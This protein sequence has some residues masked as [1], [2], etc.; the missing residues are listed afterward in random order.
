VRVPDEAGKGKAKVK[1]SF[2]A[3][4]VRLVHATTAEVTVGEKAA[5]G[6]SEAK[7]VR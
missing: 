7:S 4:K 6:K 5:D 3:W 1:V 2:E